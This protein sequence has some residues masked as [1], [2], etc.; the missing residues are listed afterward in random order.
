MLEIIV[1]YSVWKINAGIEQEYRGFMC[2]D[3][4]CIDHYNN[5]TMNL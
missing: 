5:Y 2:P 1:V 3:Q 4:V